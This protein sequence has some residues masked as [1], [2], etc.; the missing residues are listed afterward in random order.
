MVGRKRKV[1]KVVRTQNHAK[2][3][4]LSIENMVLTN[5][6][7][8][9]FH[10]K[11]LKYRG[12]PTLICSGRGK[13]YFKDSNN[14]VK[15]HRESV[16]RELYRLMPHSGSLCDSTAFQNLRTGI[17]TY[18]KYLDEYKT[19]LIPFNNDSMN[20]C[21]KHFNKLKLEGVTPS[22]ASKVRSAL[23]YFLKL[24][25]R[26]QHALKLTSV[27]R[28]EP[29]GNQIAFHIETELKPISKILIRGYKALIAHIKGNTLPIVH[30]FFDENLLRK[31][32]ETNRWDG[33]TLGAK[34]RAFKLAMQPSVLARE[35]SLLG[36]DELKRIVLFNQTS[37]CALHLF[38]MMT[39]MNA[40]VIQSMKRRDVAFKSIGTGKYI[41]K[42]MKAR[43]RNKEVDNSLG[44]S[45]YTKV[46][47][48][49]WLEASKIVYSFLGIDNVDDMPFLYYIDT[50]LKLCDFTHK[51]S[52]SGAINNLIG[53]LLPV[54]LNATRFRK[55]KS[56]VLMR[57]T[58]SMYLVS[59][60]LNNTIDVVKASYSAGVKSDHDRSL[61]VSMQAQFNIAKGMKVDEAIKKAKI[62][63]SD[64]LFD[65]DYRERLKRNKMTASTI[66]PSGVR[67][68]GDENVMLQVKRKIK[69]L[70]IDVPKNEI[71][72]TSFL[73]CFDC[74][75]HVL[76]ASELDIW[77][78]LSFREQ[79]FDMKIIP[80]QNSIPKSKLYEIEEILNRTLA[81]LK[82]KAPD[83]Y[84][85]AETRFESNGPHPLFINLRGLT[86]A[87]EVFNV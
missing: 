55:T 29:S 50:N 67:C 35:K 76:I 13:N 83:S 27:T 17:V 72:C 16:V 71:K 11:R 57:T 24:M 87:L 53:K 42:S 69:N 43:A 40:E 22:N 49:E 81:R 5:R 6:E 52:E 19:N 21:I 54:Y 74:D 64:I 1:S 41:F 85:K 60:G 38:F 62:L 59:Q 61:T 65:Y 36:I 68:M 30:P 39:G 73:S 44:F 25:G 82:E 14:L 78:M 79:V 7:G 32:A 26:T 46:L 37:R 84:E 34:K 66:T 2:V 8:C 86:D 12:V 28:N 20:G 56:D 10:M 58:E 15:A 48:E 51:K 70:D 18:F 77:I 75:N 47:I 23:V 9:R 31:M 3:E 63:N 45:K 80:S 4:P 33:Q